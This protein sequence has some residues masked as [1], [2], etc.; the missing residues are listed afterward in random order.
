MVQSGRYA[1]AADAADERRAEGRRVGV[2]PESGF[3]S[4]GPRLRGAVRKLTAMS[5]V[6]Y[7]AALGVPL[8]SPVTP[9]VAAA[10]AESRERAK[11]S[12]GRL[13]PVLWVMLFIVVSSSLHGHPRPG[14][15]GTGLWST[16]ALVGVCLLLGLNA[17]DLWPMARPLPRVGFP[18]LLGGLGLVHV[19]LEPT[20]L[21][22]LPSTAS[23]FIAFLMLP[24][25]LALAIGGVLTGVLMVVAWVVP[26]GSV[27][28]A[29]VEFVFCV[30]LGVTASSMRQAGENQDRAEILLAQLEDA[31]EAQA[32]AVAVAERTRIARELHD[33]LAQSLSGLAIQLEAAR[34]MAR[35]EEV[36]EQ[37]QT[38][39][40]RASGLV[41]EGLED[42]R[43]AVGALRGP[44]APV[45]DRLP[46][47]VERFQTDHHVDVRL[48]VE[49]T[50]RDLPSEAGLALY[51]GAQEALT[52][53][54]RYARGSKST[55][56]LRY[57]PA[58][59]VLAIVDQG[60][61]E[62]DDEYAGPPKGSGMGLI[63]M[64][65]RL[66]QVGGHAQAGPTEDADG[67]TVRM[68]VPA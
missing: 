7:P 48:S 16:A 36:G 60:R 20:T 24:T 40:D 58:E 54:S 32:R 57:A 15:H 52:N 65:E 29:A 39:L 3:G 6:T 19:M 44:P 22:T 23:V 42:A 25:R 26:G 55:V 21:S 37:L 38:V 12:A 28:L 51:R 61:T 13:R 67:W 33:V 35:R 64:R 1:V 66:A 62:T 53:V 17:A 18:V 5:A 46:E 41:K 59:V 49:G 43:R 56:T 10:F 47:L 9:R 27:W 30:V 2:T 8:T 11:R 34:R 63:G 4:L 31:R 45:L 68:E 50:P 14:L